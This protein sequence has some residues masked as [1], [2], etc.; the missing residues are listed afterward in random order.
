MKKTAL[1]GSVFKMALWISGRRQKELAVDSKTPNATV[2]DHLNGANVPIDKAIEY[3][4]AMARNGYEGLNY[5]TS[6]MSF[7]YLGFFK[8]LDG[9]VADVKSV[10]D[11]EIL[12]DIEQSEREAK[13]ERAKYLIVK[14]QISTLEVNERAE[15][16][17]Y[18]NEFLDEIVI[19]MTIVQSIADVLGMTIQTLIKQ[20]MPYW[21]KKMYMKG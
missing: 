21:I 3:F 9:K 17:N 5:I 12:L 10:N 13:R 19:E 15:L 7:Q 8:S 20:R 16:S 14:S 11:L 6:Q 2:S 4:N 1:T 18:V